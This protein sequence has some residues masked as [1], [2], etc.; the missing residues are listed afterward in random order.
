MH[1]E[2]KKKVGRGQNKMEYKI[3]L[4]SYQKNIIYNRK[5][6]EKNSVYKN[7]KES[8]IHFFFERQKIIYIYIKHKG[9]SSTRS[10]AGEYID[11]EHLNR[12]P[13]QD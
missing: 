2:R 5:V 8:V 3:K 7:W 9:H 13:I 11:A 1:A 10:T 12:P 6:R 4:S